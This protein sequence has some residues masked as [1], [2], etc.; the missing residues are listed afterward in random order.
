MFEVVSTYKPR[1]ATALESDEYAKLVDVLRS[2]DHGCAVVVSRE[3]RDT[4]SKARTDAQAVRRQL[5]TNRSGVLVRT[6]VLDAVGGTGYVGAVSSVAPPSK[7]NGDESGK[8][9]RRTS[10]K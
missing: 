2:L 6:H 1:T 4:P 7:P 9:P 5:D 3:T 10:D 8:A